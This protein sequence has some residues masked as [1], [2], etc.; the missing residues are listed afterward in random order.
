MI[1]A[2]RL[3]R[4][5]FISVTATTAVVLAIL[6]SLGLLKPE[7]HV[8]TASMTVL[9]DEDFGAVDP[10]SEFNAPQLAVTTAIATVEVAPFVVRNVL[11]DFDL[12]WTSDEIARNIQV[13][14]G[15]TA[16]YVDVSVTTQDPAISIALAQAI[17]ERLIPVAESR[18]D[19]LDDGAEPPRAVVTIVHG[20]RLLPMP[21]PALSA[22]AFVSAALLISVS[23]GVAACLMATRLAARPRPLPRA[24]A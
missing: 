22:I 4:W 24:T 10:S 6:G 17:Q 11:H 1:D 9:A 7:P 23:A 14:G 15:E 19:H 12:R 5:I 8:A 20:G 13:Q 18:V 2:L 21:S 3:H 16:S